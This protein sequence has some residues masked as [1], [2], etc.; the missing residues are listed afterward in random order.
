[1]NENKVIYLQT[2]RK[3]KDSCGTE[4]S[5]HVNCLVIAEYE[6]QT[7]ISLM[8]KDGLDI[9]GGYVRNV[10]RLSYLACDCQVKK[11]GLSF[12]AFCE[13][14]ESMEALQGCI[15]A[16]GGALTDFFQKRKETTETK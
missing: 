4:Y 11:Q 10:L 5:P 6:R 14:L 8:S 15:D 1:M 2:P 16:T 13:S 12:E 7:S 3:F 9:F